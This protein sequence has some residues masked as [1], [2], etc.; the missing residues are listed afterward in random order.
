MT[1]RRGLLAPL[2]IAAAV[3]SSACGEGSRPKPVVP[4]GPVE[5]AHFPIEAGQVPP[6]GAKYRPQLVDP[7][8]RRAHR[9]TFLNSTANAASTSSTTVMLVTTEAVV[10]WPRLSVFGLTRKP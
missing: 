8:D 1:R 7:D 6:G 5:L 9:P 4:I 2:A 3:V 10:P